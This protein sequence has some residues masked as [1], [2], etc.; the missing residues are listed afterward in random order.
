MSCVLIGII[1]KKVKN[2]LE[3]NEKFLKKVIRSRNFGAK[4][5]LAARLSSGK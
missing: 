5:E 1:L 3:K 2:F 4:L